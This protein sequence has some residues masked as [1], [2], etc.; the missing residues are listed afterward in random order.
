MIGS[1]PDAAGSRVL[2]AGIGNI[3]RADDGFGPAVAARLAAVPLPPGV[4]VWD[5]GVKGLHLAYEILDGAYQRLII[6]DVV[7]RGAAPGTIHVIEPTLERAASAALPDAHAMGPD[8]VIGLLKRLGAT[9]PSIV[10]V[11][12]EPACLDDDMALTAPVAAAV[13]DAVAVV[14]RLV[15]PVGAA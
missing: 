14:L 5:V 6:V 8:A 3:F 10:I 9:L 11:G 13:A 4:R 1:P 7:S 12:C 2:V 15:A